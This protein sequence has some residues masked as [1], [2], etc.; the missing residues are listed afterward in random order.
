MILTTK[1]SRV[2]IRVRENLQK[3][4][5]ESVCSSREEPS[6]LSLSS[7]APRLKQLTFPGTRQC[8]LCWAPGLALGPCSLE[9]SAHLLGR[10]I[11]VAQTNS[12]LLPENTDGKTWRINCVG[13]AASRN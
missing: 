3:R 5:D 7:P 9:A 2:S 6:H 1:V 8:P 13:E 12:H 11:S 4:E 10:H